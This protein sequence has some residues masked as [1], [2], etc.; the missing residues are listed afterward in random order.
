ML[1]SQMKFMQEMFVVLD[2]K[3]TNLSTSV[4]KIKLE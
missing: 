2:N 1:S 3:M 4:K